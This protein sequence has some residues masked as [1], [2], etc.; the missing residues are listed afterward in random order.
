MVLFFNVPTMR[1]G[2]RLA[3]LPSSRSE[4]LLSLVPSAFLLGLPPS[5]PVGDLAGGEGRAPPPTSV[6]LVVLGL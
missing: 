2:S 4:L 5:L 6:D 1:D 3:A